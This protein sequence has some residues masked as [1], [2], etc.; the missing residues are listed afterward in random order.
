MAIDPPP[1]LGLFEPLDAECN[2]SEADPLFCTWRDRCGALKTYLKR[3][4]QGVGRW[5]ELE[6]WEIRRWCDQWIEAYEIENGL[7][8]NEKPP[9]AVADLREAFDRLVEYLKTNAHQVGRQFA[10]DRLALPGDLYL[11]DHMDKARYVA[12]YARAHQG[13][14]R[15]VVRIRFKPRA[16]SVEL[17]LP[18]E[19]AEAARA[20]GVEAVAIKS[21]QFRARADIGLEALDGLGS[22]I[23]ALAKSGA[24]KLPPKGVS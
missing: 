13:H 8:K 14:D 20:L 9:T 18:V 19:A 22:R 5:L 11:V 2:G 16:G 10:E 4:K 21:G 3:S 24:L 12:I 7:P 6:G 23:F 1:C 15:P 17:R